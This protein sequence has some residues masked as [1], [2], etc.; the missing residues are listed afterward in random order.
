V[1]NEGATIMSN[2]QTE[3]I[4]HMPDLLFSKFCEENFEINKGVYNTI[5]CWFYQKGIDHIVNR[6]KM[7]LAF[8]QSIRF[9]RKEKVKFGP[10]GLT[11]RLNSFW[12][13]VVNGID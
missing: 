4:F 12:A 3:K 1:A 2:L 9:L 13:Q 10:K 7:I 6:R 8:C 11:S 5:D